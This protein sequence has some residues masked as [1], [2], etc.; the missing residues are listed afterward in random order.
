MSFS[1]YALLTVENKCA[2]HNFLLQAFANSVWQLN[3]TF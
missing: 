3:N 2:V 1:Y